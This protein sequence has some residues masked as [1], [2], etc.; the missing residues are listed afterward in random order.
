MLIALAIGFC[1]LVGAWAYDRVR[2]NSKHGHYQTS[3]D[4]SLRPR[5][6]WFSWYNLN[7]PGLPKRK[8][9]KS[10]SRA[11]QFLNP[12]YSADY[13]HTHM[14]VSNSRLGWKKWCHAVRVRSPALGS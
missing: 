5:R 8:V 11:D 4:P 12:C 10:S 13:E 9:L 7:P 3:A 2:R 6:Q 14:S 1:R